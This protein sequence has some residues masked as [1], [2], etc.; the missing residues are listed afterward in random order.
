MSMKIVNQSNI[1]T[2]NLYMSLNTAHLAC[3][4]AVKKREVIPGLA[5]PRVNGLYRLML[6]R[7]N[8]ANRNRQLVSE[9]LQRV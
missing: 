6:L 9:I 2:N 7:V 5:L 1:Q 4:E 3:G 8:H